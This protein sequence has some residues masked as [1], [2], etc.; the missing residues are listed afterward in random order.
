MF[1]HF[2]FEN[3]YTRALIACILSI[4]LGFIDKVDAFK[5]PEMFYFLCLFVCF[6]IFTKTYNDYGLLL[7]LIATLV[8]TH[9]NNI[10]SKL[11]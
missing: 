7:L 9:V 5:K 6:I 2:I 4:I 8:I 10:G 1:I 11:P 3:P